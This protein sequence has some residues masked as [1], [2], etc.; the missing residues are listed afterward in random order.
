MLYVY[1]LV[2]YGIPGAVL[3]Y[4]AARN[5]TTSLRYISPNLFFI[6][7]FFATAFSMLGLLLL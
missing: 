6:L 4:R 1:A 3:R 7:S 5:T 2:I